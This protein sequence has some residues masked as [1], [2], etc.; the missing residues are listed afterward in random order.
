[1]PRINKVKNRLF[2]I[3]FGLASEKLSS[4]FYQNVTRTAAPTTAVLHQQLEAASLLLCPLRTVLEQG[5][6]GGG[7][8][9]MGS[10]EDCINLPPTSELL[11]TA[12]IRRLQNTGEMFI[13]YCVLCEVQKWLH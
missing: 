10:L 9:S 12:E 5:T 13:F 7:P 3:T 6:S 4:T 1:M 11:G 8:C 2:G